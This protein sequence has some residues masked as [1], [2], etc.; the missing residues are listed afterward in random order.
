MMNASSVVDIPQVVQYQTVQQ[1]SEQVVVQMPMIRSGEIVDFP[2]IQ[3]TNTTTTSI[4]NSG[5]NPV[6]DNSG[7]VHVAIPIVSTSDSSQPLSHHGSGIVMGSN[8]PPNCAVS[9]SFLRIY[10]IISIFSALYVNKWLNSQ[11][12]NFT[13]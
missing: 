1:T 5:F 12:L 7:P 4:M 9:F 3:T 10:R 11:M 13:N 8:E 2:Y 6:I